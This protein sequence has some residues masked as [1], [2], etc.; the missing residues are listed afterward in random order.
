MTK[1]DFDAALDHFADDLVSTRHPLLYGQMQQI[2]KLRFLTVDDRA[3]ARPN[4]I[5][6]L[7]KNED[8]VSLAAY[9]GRVTFPLHAA[10]PLEYALTHEGYRIRDLPG[11]LD[12]PGKL[13]L[14]RRLVREGLV[15]IL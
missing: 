6:R 12:D 9:G 2:Q 10:E 11:E 14:I 5:Y 1:A 8:A 15:E 4:L 7:H 3:S 13:V